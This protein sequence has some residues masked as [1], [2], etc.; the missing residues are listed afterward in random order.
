MFF[1]P[2][3][4]LSSA[5]LSKVVYK[6]VCGSCNASYVGYTTRNYERRFYEH[7]NTDKK[8]HVYKHLIANSHC[9]NNSSRNSFSI[10]DKGKTR[11]ELKI[12]E[13]IW[14]KEEKPTLNGQIKSE[15]INILI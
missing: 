8:S 4:K 3:D 9:K 14:I 1:S 15:K 5:H 10:L 6:F 2:N 7:L 12:K 11:D 13:G